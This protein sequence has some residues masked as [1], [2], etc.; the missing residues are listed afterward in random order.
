[1]TLE[2]VL[3]TRGETERERETETESRLKET[4][5]N[6]VISSAWEAGLE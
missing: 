3:H 4:V 1:L 6:G 5:G 2:R